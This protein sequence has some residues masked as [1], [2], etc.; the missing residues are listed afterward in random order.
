LVSP[1]SIGHDAFTCFFNIMLPRTQDTCE[2]STEPHR[3][4]RRLPHNPVCIVHLL[5]GSTSYKVQRRP[6]IWLGT[7]QPSFLSHGSAVP[8]H[9]WEISQ[10]YKERVKYYMWSQEGMEEIQ[11]KP[12]GSGLNSDF[13]S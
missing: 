13:V 7:G 2:V 5:L 9:R 8:A 10:Q 3:W 4:W 1:M 6:V 12:V 11:D